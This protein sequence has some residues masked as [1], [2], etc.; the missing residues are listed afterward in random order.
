LCPSHVA[1]T[2]LH[3]DRMGPSSLWSLILL[4]STIA[5]TSNEASC[6]AD[7]SS[8]CSRDAGDSDPQS[9]L[10]NQKV[11]PGRHLLSTGKCAKGATVQCPGSGATCAGNQCCPPAQA[12]GPTVICPSADPSFTGCGEK[13]KT[14]DCLGDVSPAPAAIRGVPSPSPG[15][16]V[17][18]DCSGDGFIDCWHFFTSPDPTHG[19]VNYV[20]RDQA[21]N[22]GLYY[23]QDG[24]VHM[25]A[26]VGKWSRIN[27]V[28]LESNV[29]YEAGHVFLIDIAHMPTSNGAW[30][31]WWSFG[32]NWPSTGEIDTIETV[33]GENM[34]QSTLHTSPGCFQY[35]PGISNP[36]CISGNG[37]SGCGVNVPGGSGGASFNAQG[38]GVY[39]TQWS[40]EAI[41]MWWWPR[42]Q[43]PADL[44]NGNTM[45]WGP[46][47]ATFKLDGNCP[48]WHFSQQT[49]VINL[50]FCGDWAGS[51][52]KGPTGWGKD[53][54]NRYVQDPQYLWDLQEAYWAINYVKVLF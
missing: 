53:A 43:I 16:A 17:T 52:F 10:Q 23:V 3:E 12:G 15:L 27:S 24:V 33:N 49:L 36:H 42:S 34:A 51:V 50:D 1:R 35:L 9:L 19:D 7:G 39:A 29:V 2:D 4:C 28:R 45:A 8:A 47:Y 30:P 13:T 48:S 54:C 32:P 14:V 18:R 46:P 25:K 21:I 37:E 31:A 40:H 41:Y 11:K 20:P 26:S 44:D 22:E 38:G 5:A 6:T